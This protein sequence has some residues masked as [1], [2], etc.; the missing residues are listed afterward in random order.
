MRTVLQ[1]MNRADRS[2]CSV[3]QSR[4]NPGKALTLRVRGV[5]RPLISWAMVRLPD[6]ESVCSETV[7]TSSK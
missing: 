1:V 5:K 2:L 6:Q 7:S 3:P 4:R